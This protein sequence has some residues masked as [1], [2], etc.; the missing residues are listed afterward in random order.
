MILE[1]NKIEENN[2]VKIVIKSR[3][4]REYKVKTQKT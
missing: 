4:Y 2:L 3:G 1:T